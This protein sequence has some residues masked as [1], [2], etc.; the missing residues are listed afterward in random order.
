[1]AKVKVEK[2]GK[3]AALEALEKKYGLGRIEP[4]ELTIVSTGSIALNEATHIGGVPV[5][6]IIEIFGE[7]SSGKSTITLHQMSE[8][9]KAFPDKYV[10]LFDYEHCF[11]EKYATSI[12]VD[13]DKLL[14]YQPDNQ[15]IGYDMIIGLIEKELVSCVVLD[16]QT[17]ATPKSIVD[18]DMSNATISVAA[19]NNSKFCAKVKGLLDKHKATLFI[20]SQLR[21]AIGSMGEPTITT[22]GKAIRFYADMR[23][24]VWKMND[25]SNE[26]N[27]TTID[28]VKNKLGKPFGSA[29]VNIIWGEGFVKVGE[30]LDYA[31]EFD[32]IKRAGAGWTTINEHKLQGSDQVKIFLED[33]PELFLEIKEKVLEQLKN[34]D[35]E[36]TVTE[37]EGVSSGV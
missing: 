31:A 4:E 5:G 19:R 7:N 22:G 6:R 36:R 27:K 33:N 13:V 28:V 18:A 14:I 9:Q 24:K 1:M 29:M 17:A 26:L 37:S 30:I 35:S 23:W 16:S 21:D 8:F 10:A 25:K 3:E 32:I 2:Q 12:G 11:D 20:I 15:E 34:K